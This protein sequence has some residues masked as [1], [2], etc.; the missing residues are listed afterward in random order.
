[1][2]DYQVASFLGCREARI[3]AFDGCVSARNH[4]RVQVGKDADT[5]D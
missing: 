3:V 5:T 1:M 4:V 2:G